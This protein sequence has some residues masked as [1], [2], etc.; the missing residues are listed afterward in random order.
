MN[1][2]PD[3]IASATKMAVLSSF[4]AVP[5]TKYGLPFSTIVEADSAETIGFMLPVL[6]LRPPLLFDIL[7]GKNNVNVPV[8]PQI[9]R[10]NAMTNQLVDLNVS[11]LVFLRFAIFT[12]GKT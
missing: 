3:L 4:H 6:P 11:S 10:N 12:I 1:L 2:K 7:P 5:Y 8:N 9:V